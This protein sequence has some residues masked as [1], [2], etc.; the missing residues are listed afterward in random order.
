M[1]E[2]IV[3]CETCGGAGWVS[4]GGRCTTCLGR[5]RQRCVRLPLVNPTP[6]PVEDDARYRAGFNAGC[7]I[8]AFVFVAQ[9]NPPPYTGSVDAALSLVPRNALVEMLFDGWRAYAEVNPDMPE[10]TGEGVAATPALALCIAALRAREG[11]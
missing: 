3:S 11:V 4:G 10:N 9:D 2:I 8:Y 1:S 7:A 5:G 6:A